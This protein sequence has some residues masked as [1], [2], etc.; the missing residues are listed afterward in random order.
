MKEIDRLGLCIALILSYSV[1][2]SVMW[3]IIHG[4][5]SWFYVLYH[6]IKYN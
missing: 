1:N 3:M 6:L 5:F 4:F 2:K